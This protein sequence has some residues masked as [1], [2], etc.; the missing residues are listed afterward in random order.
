MGMYFLALLVHNFH[1]YD[2]FASSAN[3]TT[4]K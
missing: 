2:L 3:N 1:S 4:G